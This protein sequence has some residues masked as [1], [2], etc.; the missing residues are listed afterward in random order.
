MNLRYHFLVGRVVRL[1]TV[2]R[3]VSVIRHIRRLIKA[4]SEEIRVIDE[5]FTALSRVDTGLIFFN[6]FICQ[7]CQCIQIFILRTY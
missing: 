3:E 1:K 2:A 6:T 4:N 5:S 7:A